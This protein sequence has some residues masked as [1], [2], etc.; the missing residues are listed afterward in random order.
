LG[1][2]LILAS[3][4]LY[5]TVGTVAVTNQEIEARAR[6][7]GMVYREE[8][9]VFQEEQKQ[10]SPVVPQ[11]NNSVSP[12]P[13]QTQQSQAQDRNV[14]IIKIPQYSTLTYVT[15]LLCRE[16]VIKDRKVFAKLAREKN[17]INRIKAGTY[18]FPVGANPEDV[19]RM[20]SK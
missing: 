10:N 19:V 20:I 11:N 18:E 2:G 15:D 7:L 4:I 5:K 9:V 1:I 6:E 17:I 13:E 16:G 8:V 12:V 3:S 14:R